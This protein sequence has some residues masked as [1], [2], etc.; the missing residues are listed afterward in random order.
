[1]R[2][3]LGFFDLLQIQ[4][5]DGLD[6]SSV[7]TQ[8]AH[9]PEKAPKGKRLQSVYLTFIF[10]KSFSFLKNNYLRRMEEMVEK[11]FESAYEEKA[12]AHD[13]FGQRQ[14]SNQ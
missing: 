11:L 10:Y 4:F 9:A 7:Y 6:K 1:M 3:Q 14:K 2:V 8:L 13:H 12:G 5:C